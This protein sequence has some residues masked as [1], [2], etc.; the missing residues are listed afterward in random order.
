MNKQFPH[1]LRSEILCLGN[2]DLWN[3]RINEVS[4]SH[5]VDGLGYGVSSREDFPGVTSRGDSK[6][7]HLDSGLW[8]SFSASPPASPYF[9]F[10]LAQHHNSVHMLEVPASLLAPLL[11]IF[12]SDSVS[13]PTTSVSLLRFWCFPSWQ[14]PFL[15]HCSP[16]SSST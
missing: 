5:S 2:S 9:P 7:S 16:A 8:L 15:L 11:L 12:L 3:R 14:T 4:A 13:K 1:V 10:P 6:S